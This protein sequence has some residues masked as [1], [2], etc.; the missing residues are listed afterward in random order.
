M[1]TVT[2]KTIA[3]IIPNLRD[4]TDRISADMPH[5]SVEEIL[6][7]IL[8]AS[9]ANRE[10]STDHIAAA[11][12]QRIQARYNQSIFFAPLLD[13]LAPFAPRLSDQVVQEEIFKW[14]DGLVVLAAIGVAVASEA[15]GLGMP[16]PQAIADYR[17][18]LYREIAHDYG[19]DANDEMCFGP[20][21]PPSSN[22]LIG[23][24]GGLTFRCTTAEGQEFALPATAEEMI[25]VC[26]ELAIDPDHELSEMLVDNE[27]ITLERA[28][29]ALDRYCFI[30]M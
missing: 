3:E 17:P 25:G 22:G 19:S 12:A 26:E 7:I 1:Q 14:S 28:R 4:I 11:A 18:L 23:I 15:S 27:P 21:A 29:Q 10:K 8:S 24:A 2:T 9:E 6:S 20:P 30:Y 5:T 13:A 16:M